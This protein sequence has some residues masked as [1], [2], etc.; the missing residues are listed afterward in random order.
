MIMTSNVLLLPDD[1]I[2]ARRQVQQALDDLYLIWKQQNA[3]GR[4]IFA[5]K[6]AS[7]DYAQLRDELRRLC[8]QYTEQD[9]KLRLLEEAYRDKFT[10]DF[11]PFRTS[12]NLDTN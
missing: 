2:E 12:I 6:R 8:H 5:A 1:Q 3:C 10:S 9:D 7:S 4:R 11:E